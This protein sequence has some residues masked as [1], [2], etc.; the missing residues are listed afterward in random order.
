[1]N[2]TS[3]ERYLI[4]GAIRRAFR[5]N[6]R[7]K[8]ILQAARVELPPKVLKDGS[9]GKKNQIRYRCNKCKKLFPLKYCQVDHIE[10]VV[11]LHL[12]ELEMDFEQIAVRIFAE[13]QN[14][15]V[16][17]STPMKFLPKGQKSCHSL[18]TNQE[19]FIRDLW[20]DFKRFYKNQLD[21]DII[22]K[23]TEIYVKKYNFYL[24]EKA[25]LLAEKEER[26]KARELKKLFKTKAI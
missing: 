23:N 24:L 21:K 7:M 16:L 12:N 8:T 2:L 15:Q 11:P 6:E 14:L 13:L 10:P 19:N 20:T 18:K 5:Q 26:K 3:H 17:C 1:M 25:K 4:K 22:E 9:V